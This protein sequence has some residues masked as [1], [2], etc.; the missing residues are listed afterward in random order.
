MCFTEAVGR[1]CSFS[2]LLLAV[3]L[4]LVTLLA[5]GYSWASWT[6][7]LLLLTAVALCVS[8]IPAGKSKLESRPQV[9]P[10]VAE[11]PGAQQRGYEDP[12]RWSFLPSQGAYLANTAL[13]EEYENELCSMKC[14]AMHRPTHE[15]WR[16]TGKDYPYSWHLSGR[17]RLWEIR[18]QLRFKRLPSSKLYFGLELEDF[19]PASAAGRHIKAVL[20]KAVQRVVG[21]FY[22]A[23]GDD[24]AKVNNGDEPEPPTFVMPLWAFDQFHVSE[25]GQEPDLTGDL[26]S[27]GIR[28]TDG[29]KTYIRELKAA[30]DNFSTSK[31][32]TFCIWGVSQFLDCMN[33]EARGI[34]PGLR[35]SFSR[36]GLRPPVKIVIYEIPGQHDDPRHLVSRKRYYLQ[37][38]MWSMLHPPTPE[39]LRRL[40]GSF[41]DATSATLPKKYSFS[42]ALDFFACCAGGFGREHHESTLC[43]DKVPDVAFGG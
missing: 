13:P 3:G 16:E 19:E 32:Y 25:V 18:L 15:P 4:V 6:G 40:L 29:L 39:R 26:E 11:L 37:V 8:A 20:L 21:D 38:A 30:T 22:Y 7:L 23:D 14:L 28:R 31:V 42:G 9:Q 24:P 5:Q 33:W 41:A 35:F 17:K 1:D 27:V 2:S 34:V 10:C 36:F 43:I 12:L